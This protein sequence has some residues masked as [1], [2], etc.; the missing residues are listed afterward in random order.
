MPYRGKITAVFLS[1]LFLLLPFLAAQ[2]DTLYLTNGRSLEGIIKRE[3]AGIVELDV[4]FGTITF[5][6]NQIKQIRRSTPQEAGS[7]R[8]GWEKKKVEL[9]RAPRSV[10]F[11][12]DKGSI[13][14]GAILNESADCL[15][16]LDTGA[17][18]VVLRKGVAPKLGIDLS[19]VKPDASLQLADGRQVRAKRVILKSV[20]VEGAEAKNVEA[21]IMLDEAKDFQF[22]DG[23]LGMSFLK[24]FNFKVDH[25]QGKLILE[26]Y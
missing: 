15:L 21:A 23:L 5:E 2:A 13:V 6:K 10:E 7:I 9:E 24:K 11:S 8:R 4:G 26:K 17:S 16:V 12:R 1:S 25:K 19:R 22:S 20:R 3:D 18:V 14:L